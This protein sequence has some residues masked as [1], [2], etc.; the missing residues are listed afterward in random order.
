MEPIWSG[1][2]SAILSSGVH[3]REPLL[4]GE[5]GLSNLWSALVGMTHRGLLL[6]RAFLHMGA[7]PARPRPCPLSLWLSA[8]SA[9]PLEL[10]RYISNSSWR[11]M[12]LTCWTVIIAVLRRV[13]MAAPY[14]L[15]ILLSVSDCYSSPLSV[16]VV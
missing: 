13:Q 1:P 7:A 12:V 3:Q 4:H 15:G 10:P 9:V 16:S 6:A 11:S 2:L 8:A 5:F 14:W